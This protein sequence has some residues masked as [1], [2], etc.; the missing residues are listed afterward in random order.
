MDAVGAA[1]H[2]Q[3]HAVEAGR[4]GQLEDTVEAVVA[5]RAAGKIYPSVHLL[6]VPNETG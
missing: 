1:V 4:A 6:L 5:Q 2:D 3:L